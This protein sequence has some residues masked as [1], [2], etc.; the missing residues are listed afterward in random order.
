MRPRSCAPIP[1]SSTSIHRRWR[2]IMHQVRA[3]ARN[4]LTRV[5]RPG[6]Q[7]MAGG[8]D[9]W[10]HTRLRLLRQEAVKNLRFIPFDPQGRIQAV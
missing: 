5:R 9:Y 8:A 3:G 2:P 10:K 6:I 4:T 7:K 1:G